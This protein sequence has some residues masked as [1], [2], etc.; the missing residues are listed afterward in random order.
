MLISLFSSAAPQES[1]IVSLHNYPS[2]GHSE[3]TM[4]I[5]ERLTIITE[6][7]MKRLVFNLRPSSFI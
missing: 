7:V 3:S 2:F 1:M 4:C 5:G 6:Y